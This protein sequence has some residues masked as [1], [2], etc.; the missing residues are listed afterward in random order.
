MADISVTLV[1]D[2][3]QYQG[4]LKAATT[5][6]ED[7]GKKGVKAAGDVS[8]GLEKGGVNADA[9]KGKMEKLQTILLGAGFVEFAR[10]SLETSK[11]IVDLSKGSDV[12]IPKILQLREAFEANGGSAEKLGKIIS[13]L[14]Q[15][16]EQAR[17]GSATAQETLLK[18]GLSFKDMASM[19]TDEALQ[20][21][22]NKLAAMEDPINRNALALQIFGKEA[23]NINWKG[24]QEGTS[25][26][27]E[28]Y[29]K[30]SESLLKAQEAQIKLEEASTKLQIAFVN[31]LDK[32]GIL[33]FINNMN[34]DFSKFEK[35]VTAAGT[36]FA[37]YF[38][39]SAFIAVKE[40]GEKILPML[41]TGF[42]ATT[43]AVTRLDTALGAGLLGKFTAVAAAA[44]LLFRSEDL[45]QGEDALIKKIHKQE[46]EL[47]DLPAKYRDAY[48]K[49]DQEDKMRVQ[50][51]YNNGKSMA[52]AIAKVAKLPVQGESIKPAWAGEIQSLKELSTE[53]EKVSQRTLENYNI[54]AKNGTLTADQVQKMTL[55]RAE[56]QK[57][58][59]QLDAINKQERLLRENQN[60]GN[61]AATADKIAELE[62]Q[63][64]AITTYYDG[65]EKKFR[66]NI[67]SNQQVAR[68]FGTGWKEAFT[69]YVDD[70]TNAAS[71]GKAAFDVM[72]NAMNNAIDE[73]VMKGTFSFKSFSTGIIQELEKIA[74]KAAAAQV[75]KASGIG[76][77]FGAVGGHAMGGSI[78][79]GQWGIVGEQGPE[80]VKG[81][82]AVVTANNTAGMMG[83]NQTIINN[84]S[85]ID[86]KSVAQLFAEN[87]MTL[88]GTVEQARRELPM[89]TR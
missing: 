2:D 56:Y 11:Q 48:A 10:R 18:L 51:M 37:L 86:S 82:A 59:D 27:T 70:A 17:E 35:I 49:L 24:I 28:E 57:Y 72:T 80:L 50:E 40:L 29:N 84:I 1:L 58:E 25:S 53:F 22:I 45:N 79:S 69:K 39:A 75:F 30:Y 54:Q 23:K 15:S 89:R 26:S 60:A 66:A 14:S 81:P 6:I 61:A 52:E 21:T 20:A 65:F 77:L 7:F 85:A 74:L 3:S 36:A 71:Q 47:A 12:S 5:S 4:K 8:S 87:R 78:P 43:A 19:G 9:F 38:G 16:L 68:E 42:D 67:E 63:K 44:Y 76:D 62:K 46:D 83:N 33:S 73:F 41:V 55:L 13:K 64:A 88:F 32:S 34:N 31:L